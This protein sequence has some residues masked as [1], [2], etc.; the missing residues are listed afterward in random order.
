MNFDLP[1]TAPRL[2]EPRVHLS[3]QDSDRSIDEFERFSARRALGLMKRRLGRERLL[4][5][6]SEEIEAGEAFL[7]SHLQRSEGEET[8]GTTTLRAHGITAAEFGIWLA[9]AFAREDVMIAGHPE[10]YSIHAEP[11]QSVNIVETLDEY[12]CSFFMRPWNDSVVRGQELPG[13]AEERPAERR[14]HILLADGTVIGSIAN[15][16]EEE[17]DGFTAR[18][19][20]TLP[21]TCAPDVIEQHL[22]HFAVEF[23]FWILQAAADLAA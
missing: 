3:G 8:T 6:L 22:E 2:T 21:S 16:F 5:L 10:H 12:V 15:A 18:L 1:T 19:S 14:S 11:G 9:G 13:L 23:R 4:E 7:R 20:V 17:S